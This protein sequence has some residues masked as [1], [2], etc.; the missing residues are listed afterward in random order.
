MDYA[1]VNQAGPPTSAEKAALN[2]FHDL[3]LA[4]ARDERGA[5]ER[6]ARLRVSP[7]GNLVEEEKSSLPRFQ[8]SPSAAESR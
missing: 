1:D 5:P 2:V 4:H 8:A 6:A 7:E 3:Q